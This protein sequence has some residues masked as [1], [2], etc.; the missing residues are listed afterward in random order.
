L[1][2][3]NI[4]L[5]VSGGIAAYKAAELSRLFI[6]QGSQ[7][8][9]V[10]TDAATKF[11]TPLTFEALTGYPVARDMFLP[12]TKASIEH[13]SLA[14]W[15]TL[16]VV[17]PATANVIAKIACGIADD[18]LTTFILAARC[19]TAIVPAM[20]S[21]MFNSLAV[22]ENIRTLQR[23]GFWVLE[24]EEGE[25][26]C[27]DSGQGRMPEPEKI[28]AFIEDKCKG[29]LHPDLQGVKIIVTAGPTREPLDPVRFLTN[30]SSGRMGYA[31]ASAAVKR[32]ADVTLISGPVSLESPVGV[33][34]IKVETAEEMY[35]AVM[36][37]F[38]LADVVIK[39][40]AVADYRLAFKRSQKIK[41]EKDEDFLE[42]KLI[43]NPDILA[44]LGRRKGNKILVGFAAETEKLLENAA[45]KLKGKNLDLIVANDLTEEGAGFNVE[46][47]K[48]KI[49]DQK[50]VHQEL[51][52]A[53]KLDVAHKLLDRVSGMLKERRKEC[54]E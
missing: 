38:P 6:K 31:I 10:M 20:N 49:L 29:L 3:E 19:P 23:R 12:R 32:G 4:V 48:V 54:K 46:T 37:H 21:N 45:T 28:L 2:G 43:R 36:Q 33:R 14:R 16:I 50:G 35:Q 30:Y 51:P 52:L 26:A 39:A 53:S 9:V 42:L 15:A 34:L 13:I 47:N 24:P 18:L 7:V 40:A 17:A 5:G 22:Q 1:K 11:V 27:G 41:K 44:E 25:L 8:K